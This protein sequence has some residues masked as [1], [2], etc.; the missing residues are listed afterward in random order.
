[1]RKKCNNILILS[2]IHYEQ[3]RMTL[4]YDLNKISHLIIELFE[5]LLNNNRD[6]LAQYENGGDE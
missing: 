1:M 2:C 4:F 3:F 6:G 5:M